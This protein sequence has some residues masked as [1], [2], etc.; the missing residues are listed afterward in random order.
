MADGVETR[1]QV[2]R[3]M[4]GAGGVEIKAT[5]PEKQ[6]D[7]ALQAYNLRPSNNER[8]IYFFDTPQ[9]EA[10]RHGSHRPGPEDR[11]RPA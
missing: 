10:V 4:E 5:I 1:G 2:A 11:R 8:Y 6:V 7:M 3:V 9:L